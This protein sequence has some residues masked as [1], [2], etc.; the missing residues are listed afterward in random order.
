MAM[1]VM[2]MIVMEIMA[3][4]VCDDLDWLEDVTTV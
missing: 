3:V 2:M 4:G 1:M